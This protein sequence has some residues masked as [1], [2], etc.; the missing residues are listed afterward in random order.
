MGN[1]K[2]VSLLQK[3]YQRTSEGRVPWQETEMP[4]VFQAA[5]PGY[6]VRIH[7]DPDSGDIVLSLFN[8]EGAQIEE[9]TDEDIKNELQNS[10]TLMKD[11]Y[12]TARRTAMGVEEALDKI[13]AEL[14]KGKG[15]F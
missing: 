14:D 3:L 8:E 1:E 4:E 7:H 15:D 6:A 10:F 11:L 9:V 5:F 12:D 13:L 2:M